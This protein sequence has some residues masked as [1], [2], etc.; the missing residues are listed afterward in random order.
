MAS[1]TLSIVPE[2]VVMGHDS[3]DEPS[4]PP[5][6]DRRTPSEVSLRRQRSPEKVKRQAG[7]VATTKGDKER[8]TKKARRNAEDLISPTLLTWVVSAG[9]V[10]L[11]SAISFSA[12]YSMGK[13]VGRTEISLVDVGEG[14]RCGK[15]AVRGL[16]RLR[17][18]TA[19]PGAVSA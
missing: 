5:S 11:V 4:K 7:G 9:V 10:V 16:G 18:S 8:V 2:S 19:A 13:E 6:L 15:E 1:E 3:T 17:W 12:G 14:R